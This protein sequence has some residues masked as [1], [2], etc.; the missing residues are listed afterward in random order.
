MAQLGGIGKMVLTMG[1]L[2]TV[3]QFKAGEPGYEDVV[4]YIRGVYAVAEIRSNLASQNNP[5]SLTD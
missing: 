4:F 1:A 3:N 5:S 2:Y